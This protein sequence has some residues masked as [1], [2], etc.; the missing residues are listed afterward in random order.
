[1]ITIIVNGINNQV[2]GVLRMYKTKSELW[3]SIFIIPL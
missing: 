3:S 1:M 2:V